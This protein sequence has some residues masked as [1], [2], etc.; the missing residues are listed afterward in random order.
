LNSEEFAFF[1]SLAFVAELGAVF[2]WSSA[3]KMLLSK[4]SVQI[5]YRKVYLYYWTGFFVDLVV[6]CE[7]VCGEIA[8]LVLIQKE[9]K[10]DYGSLTA[11]AVTN[12]VLAYLIVI[13]G[14]LVVGVL[15][16]FNPEFPGYLFNLFLLVLVGA[17]IYLGFLLYLALSKNAAKKITSGYVRL[18]TFFRSDKSPEDLKEETNR[19]LSRYYSGFSSFRKTPKNLIAPFVFHLV[20]YSLNLMVYALVFFA[21]GITTFSLPFLIVVYFIVTAIQD[22]SASFSVGSLDILLTTILAVYGLT[23]AISGITALA[24]R[25]AAFWFP[26]LVGFICFQ[27]VGAKNLLQ[28][29]PDKADD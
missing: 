26:L 6:P 13:S 16:F 24:I 9:T 10:K 23:T 8:R 20:A 17:S 19:A 2:F 29:E 12:R 4:V 5:S 25:S 27:I 14:L 28:Q 22:A 11:S 18:Y 3:W 7:T 15:I 1:Y 21:L